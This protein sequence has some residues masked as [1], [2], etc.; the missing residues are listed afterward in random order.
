VTLFPSLRLKI[1][2]PG[3]AAREVSADTASSHV[4]VDL[5]PDVAARGRVLDPKDRLVRG[6]VIAT[7][8]ARDRGSSSVA[9]IGADGVFV[10]TGLERGHSYALEVAPDDPLLLPTRFAV[11]APA[12]DLGLV[13]G[14]ATRIEV[15][16]HAPGDVAIPSWLTPC[17]ESVRPGELD[18]SSAE[19]VDDGRSVIDRV[20][21]GTYR[22]LIPRFKGCAPMLSELVTVEAPA[23]PRTLAVRVELGPGRCLEG[24][25]TDAAGAPLESVSVRELGP[26][27]A[28][29]DVARTDRE[30]RFVIE[31]AGD[32]PLEFDRRDMKTKRVQ[33]VPGT[34]QIDIV[35]ERS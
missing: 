35:L 16:L 11:T 6:H 23:E 9:P 28:M 29:D 26:E 19:A 12:A 2:S 8:R 14:Y 22:I 27:H 15:E 5:A 1:E 18:S 32:V 33:L 34:S 30:G 17:L 20:A 25:V 4:A 7:D 21:P 13:V 24:R 10:L 31:N 3:H